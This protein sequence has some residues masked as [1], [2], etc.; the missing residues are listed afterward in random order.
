MAVEGAADVVPPER[1]SRLRALLLERE[2]L[3]RMCGTS[4]FGNDAGFAF[5]LAQ[6]SRLKEDMLRVNASMFGHRML[7]DAVVPGGVARDIGESD[8]T[9]LRQEL[10]TLSDGITRLQAIYDDHPGLQDRL[11]STGV[12]TP[13]LAERLGLTGLAGRA[14]GQLNDQRVQFPVAPYGKLAVVIQGQRRGDVA[15]RMT[16]RFDEAMESL[17]LCGEI[18]DQIP[19]GAI[20]KPVPDALAGASGIG[21]IEG[22]RGDILIALETAADNRIGRLHAH[23]PSWQNW[24]VLEH[25]VLGNIVPDFPLINKSF[26]LSYSGHDL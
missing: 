25:A 14:S 18:L 26:N 20:L 3:A 7:M 17:R 24:P 23:D 4:V 5:G 22:W 6:F 21:W 8:I 9:R 16:V 12:V 19:D 2:R 15:A 13:E 1:A 11:L 10:S